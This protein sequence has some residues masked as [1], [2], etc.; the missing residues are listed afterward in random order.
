MPRLLQGEPSKE[1][2]LKGATYPRTPKADRMLRTRRRLVLIKCLYL[3]NKTNSTKG[4]SKE[5]KVVLIQPTNHNGHQI[6]AIILRV[7]IITRASVYQLSLISHKEV[8]VP[9]P[10][11]MLKHLLDQ[12]YSTPHIH[13]SHK[14]D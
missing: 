4:P 5:A 10:Q 12:Y 9:A 8:V 14:Q 3:E 2:I 6:K 13:L 11:W 1:T 7:T